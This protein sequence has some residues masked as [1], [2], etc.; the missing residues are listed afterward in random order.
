MT[1]T[2][3]LLRD[4]ALD[5]LA[6]LAEG[7]PIYLA[8]ARA[9]GSR[10]GDDIAGL[11]ER[12]CPPLNLVVSRGRYGSRDAWRARWPHEQGH[13]GGCILL[14]V[15]EPLA[16]DAEPSGVP[17]LHIVDGAG[18]FE[19]ATLAGTGRPVSWVAAFGGA[20]HV[21]SRFALEATAFP[22]DGRFARCFTASDA[23]PFRPAIGKLPFAI[24]LTVVR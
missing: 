18:A 14:T 4:P 23:D 7:R 16:E 17:G 22:T 20:F 8:V 24:P 10:F 19:V 12:K 9:V 6:E 5:R 1:A 3:A 15:A 13:Y 11:L 2:P 21:I